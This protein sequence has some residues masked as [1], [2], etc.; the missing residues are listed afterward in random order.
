[1]LQTSSRWLPSILLV[2]ALV[3]RG[4][5]GNPSTK[6][7]AIGA[8]DVLVTNSATQQIPV[9]P[10]ARPSST[11]AY[12]VAVTNVPSV[13]VQNSASSPVM[14]KSV[15]EGSATTFQVFNASSL[16]NGAF[17]AG[18]NAYVVPAGKRFI[19]EHLSVDSV[20]NHPGSAGTLVAVSV[21]KGGVTSALTAVPCNPAPSSQYTSVGNV[22]TMM[23]ADAGQQV[24]L[25]V[26]RDGSV[27]G[28]VAINTTISGHLVNY[29]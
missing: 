25:I 15:D 24:F 20:A 16:Q 23:V 6:A 11:G 5:A 12:V 21:T 1:M 8:Q 9:L 3:I 27:D 10:A 19:I 13:N 4:Y 2:A 29:P 18:V 7:S 14:T 17:G 28:A 22:A 26:E